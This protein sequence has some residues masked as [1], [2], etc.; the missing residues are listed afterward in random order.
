MPPMPV[1][2]CIPS[3]PASEYVSG[4]LFACL[5][6]AGMVVAVPIIRS[7]GKLPHENAFAR[8]PMVTRIL[9]LVILLVSVPVTLFVIGY[10]FSS[11]C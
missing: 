3:L 11:L 4:I 7:I 1:A 6:L 2:T 10:K 9:A 8:V 5:S